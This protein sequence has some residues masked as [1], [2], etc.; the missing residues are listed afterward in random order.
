MKDR[1]AMNTRSRM[2]AA[3][4]A[5]T[6]LVTEI[7]VGQLGGPHGAT[8]LPLPS[9]NQPQ[10]P[11]PTHA[12]VVFAVVDG[13]KLRLDVYEP[14]KHSSLTAGIIVIHG[15]GFTDFDRT[16]MDSDAAALARAGFVTFSV[17]YR[18]FQPHRHSPRNAWPTQLQDCQT[19]VR[20]IRQH[21]AQYQVGPDRIGAYGH[22]AGGQL[23]ALVGL[24]D[25]TDVAAGSVSSRVQAV[26]DLS[27]PSDFT[28][29]FDADGDAFLALYLGGNEPQAPATWRDASPVFRVQ[30]GAP[31]FL[32]VHGTRDQDVPIHQSEELVDALRKAGATVTFLK[33]ND[34]HVLNG[35]GVRDQ[36]IAQ[37]V[38]FFSEVLRQRE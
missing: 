12:D 32:I 2:M 34:D 7:A 5:A 9:G 31:P 4:F 16:V 8:P 30:P 33:M 36:V 3:L 19:A 28:S 22:S 26:A 35:V 6:L 1:A 27:G 10:T 20:W 18:L 13:Q 38:A 14:R 17:D 11:A 25:A 37:A 15:G 29:D 23:A 24:T 21:A